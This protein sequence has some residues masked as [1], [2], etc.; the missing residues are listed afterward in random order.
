MGHAYDSRL[1]RKNRRIVLEG[2]PLCAI[3]RK[4][5]AT[6]ADHIVPVSWGG[7]HSLENLRPACG[8]CNFSRGA[9]GKRR[10]RESLPW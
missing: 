4:R 7:D 3:C 1:Y 6:T 9:K 5:R 10:R 2:S 8:P